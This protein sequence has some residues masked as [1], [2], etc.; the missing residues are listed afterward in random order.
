M[1][2]RSYSAEDKAKVMAA[3]A[4]NEGN[5]KGTA[6]ETGVPE[7]SIRDWKKQAERR[8]LPAEVAEALPAVVDDVLE[9]METIRSKALDELE[10]Q[11]EAGQVKGQALITSI[12][13]LTDKIRLLQGQATD[14]KEIVTEGPTPEE[15]GIALQ[16]YLKKTLAAGF[17][18]DSEIVDAEYTE[19]ASALPAPSSNP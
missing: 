15:M 10:M 17:Q 19:Q 5:V 11:I 3:L 6:R 13:V 8:G 4:A 18:R 9:R 2:K 1:A 7:Q 16:D 14:R 12:G